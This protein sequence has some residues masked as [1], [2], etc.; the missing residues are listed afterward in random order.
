MKQY[1]VE[2]ALYTQDQR[3]TSYCNAIT[4]INNGAS[5]ILVNNFPV[6]A[7]ATLDISGN[8]GEIDVTEYQ[9]NFLGTLGNCWVIK[10]MFL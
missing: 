8:A 9:I 6:V 10:K 3:L 7:G 4:F 1:R 2:L 5:T